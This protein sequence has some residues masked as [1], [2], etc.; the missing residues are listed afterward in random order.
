[1]NSERELVARAV[2][3]REAERAL[4]ILKRVVS[5]LRDAEPAPSFRTGGTQKAQRPDGPRAKR[6][7]ARHARAPHA[8]A[9]RSPGRNSGEEIS[10][11]S[12]RAEADM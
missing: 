6:A 4:T 8:S 2:G 12:L 11:S 10:L 3:E 1:M 5:N 9:S 7:R